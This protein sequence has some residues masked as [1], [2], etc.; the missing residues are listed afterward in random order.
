MKMESVKD[1][2]YDHLR[3]LYDAEKLLVKTLPK[4]AK[5]VTSED[6][7]EAVQSHLQETENQVSRLEQIFE[8]LGEPAKSKPC[9]GMRGLLEEG[10]SVMEEDA[11]DSILDLAI[12][13]AAQ[14]V[15]HYE[16]SAYGTARELAER[17]G[18]EEI[19]MLLEETLEEEKAADEKLTEVSRALLQEEEMGGEES[20]EQEDEEQMDQKGRGRQPVAS[21]GARVRSGNRKAS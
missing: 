19:V 15:E 4:I 12:I 2:L 1:L 16:I 10:K 21:V 6:L 13:A 17:M 11:S 8:R 9:Q 20:G 3:D 18:E 5:T 7:R 14:K